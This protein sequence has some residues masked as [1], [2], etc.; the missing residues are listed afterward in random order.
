MLN[1][2]RMASWHAPAIAQNRANV[3]APPR[4]NLMLSMPRSGHD[5]PLS[6]RKKCRQL[7]MMNVPGQLS[8]S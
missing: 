8:G 6:S 4:L 3:L 7:R 1:A 5:R 2:M